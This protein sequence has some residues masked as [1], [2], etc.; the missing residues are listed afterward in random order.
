MLHH[1]GG[2]VGHGL[3]EGHSAGVLPPGFKTVV[4]FAG[5]VDQGLARPGGAADSQL[6]QG[7]AV[8][9]HGMPLEVGQHQHGVIVHDVFAQV[10]LLKD[11]S[12][13]DGPDHVRT[14]GVHQVHIEVLGPAVLLQELPMGLRVVPHATGRVAVGGVA[15]HDGSVDCLHHGPPEL[16]AQKILVA[17]FPGVNLHRHPAGQLCPQGA[18]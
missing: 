1:A 7:A 2:S 11:F 12:V 6:L 9:A 5:G 18:V 14:L 8:A 4:C 13:W 3:R 16:R 10:V 17:F 15:F